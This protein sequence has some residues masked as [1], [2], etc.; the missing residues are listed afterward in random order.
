[1]THAAAAH[2]G[3]TLLRGA[4]PVCKS[5]AMA[6]A[7]QH[8]I[9]KDISND[10]KALK[11]NGRVFHDLS[12]IKVPDEFEGITTA[13]SNWHLMVDEASKFKC[14]K[15]FETKRGM[16]P[17]LPK[18]MHVKEKQGYPIKILQQDNAK[19]NIAAI[20]LARG[21]DWKIVFKAEFTAQKTP[22]QNL[23]IQTGFTVLAAQA[24]SM[25]NAAQ[26]PD[27]LRFKLWAETVMT[28]TYLNNLVLV[29]VQ[30]ETRTR[31]EHADFKLPLWSKNLRTYREAGMVKE[32]K[33]RKVL[34]C[35]VNMMFI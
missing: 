29:T 28:A 27:E 20:K 14:S 17:D 15:F 2:L 6:K 21:K 34:D 3:M 32:G 23:V 10:S 26:S 33:R 16:I 12:K 18:Y 8:N 35:G 30:G 24:R 11:F 4:L 1:M 5:C 31:W 13:K 22:Q 19:E 25:M 7:H 9:P